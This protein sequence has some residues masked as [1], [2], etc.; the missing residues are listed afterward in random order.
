MNG[1]KSV[2][3]SAAIWALS[4]RAPVGDV[5]LPSFAGM[6]RILLT[7][8]NWRLGNTVLVLPLVAAFTDAFPDVRFEFLGGPSSATLLQGYPLDAVHTIDRGTVQNPIRFARALSRVRRGAY[9]AVVHVHSST[10][11]I[12]AVVT[13]MSGAPCRVGCRRPRGNAFFTTTV[14]KPTALHKRDRIDEMRRALGLPVATGSTLR[15]SSGERARAQSRL[16]TLLPR[17]V[18]PRIAVLLSGRRRKGKAWRLAYF[19]ALLHGLRDRG[20]EPWVLLGP[21]EMRRRR[22][23]LRALAYPVHAE[24]LNLRDAAASLG[25]SSAVVCPDS[26]PMHLAIACGV[27]TVGLFR[28]STGAVYGPRRS[29]GAVVFDPRGRDVEQTLAAVERL[30]RPRASGRAG[31]QSGPDA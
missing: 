26:G 25:A 1:I 23:I 19:R 28:R 14:P 6:D 8:V 15:W 7:Y 22:T 20:F 9:D 18:R 27:P 13:G 29:E 16:T 4:R 17:S 5:P 3:R 12:G 21:E 24:G 11:T 30:L 2:L 10:G 31:Q